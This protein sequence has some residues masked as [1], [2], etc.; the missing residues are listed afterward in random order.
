MTDVFLAR[1]ISMAE[2]SDPVTG[3][4]IVLLMNGLSWN[5][6][7]TETPIYVSTL[8]KHPCLGIRIG[9]LLRCL[10]SL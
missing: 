7:P 2:I 9:V 1:Y 6:P 10:P 8:A 5:D 4:P 3:A